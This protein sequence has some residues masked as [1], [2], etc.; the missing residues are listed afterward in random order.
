[1]TRGKRVGWLIA[2][3]SLQVFFA[4]ASEAA[5]PGLTTPF[6]ISRLAAREM[7]IEVTPAA[8]ISNPM[9]CSDPVIVRVLMSASNYQAI[10]SEIITTYAA[11]KPITL[12]V[13]ACD[14]DGVPLATASWLIREGL[15]VETGATRAACLTDRA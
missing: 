1:M 9:G 14:T 10:T 3:L 2:F 4:S 11:N 12:W 6:T 15:S 13:N 5:G 8:G 7:G